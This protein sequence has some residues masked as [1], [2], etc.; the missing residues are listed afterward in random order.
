MDSEADKAIVDRLFTKATWTKNGKTKEGTEYQKRDKF[1]S[2][3]LSDEEV[4]AIERLSATEEGKKYLS[5]LKSSSK[6]TRRREF[7]AWVITIKI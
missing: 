4:E 3:F 6:A 2:G 7:Q 5:S 1:E